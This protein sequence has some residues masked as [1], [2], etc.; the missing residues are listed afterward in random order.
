MWFHLEV[1]NHQVVVLPQVVHSL[2]HL[3]ATF[4]LQAAVPVLRMHQ[5]MYACVTHN[6]S[7]S[8]CTGSALCMR[9]CIPLISQIAKDF[10]SRQ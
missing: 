7:A 6:A 10:F 3:A 1:A 8:G 9:F 4:W 5:C 2:V